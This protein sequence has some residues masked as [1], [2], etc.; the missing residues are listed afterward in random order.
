MSGEEAYAEASNQYGLMYAMETF[1]QLV[2][3]SHLIGS[4]IHVKDGAD[5][6]WRG[7][8]IDSGRRFVPVDT[9]KNIMDTAS[10]VKMNVLHLHASDMCRFGVES[11][12]Y[13]NLTASLTGIHEGFYSQEDIQDLVEHAANVGMRLVPEFDVPGHSRGFRPLMGDGVDLSWRQ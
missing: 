9:L 3:Q 2:S 7:I 10:A 6:A 4:E 5:Y 1:A 13:P 12:K 8:M 11:K